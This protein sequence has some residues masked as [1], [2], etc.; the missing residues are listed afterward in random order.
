[1]TSATPTATAGRRTVPNGLWGMLLFVTTEAVL[2]TT[3]VGT[4]FYLHF[5]STAWPPPGIKPPSV[6]LPLALTGLLVLTTAPIVGAAFAARAR[7]R[8]LAMALI[9]LAMGLQ[10]GYL[11]WQLVLFLRDLDTFPA[12]GTAYGSAYFTMLG[13]HHIHVA[14]G[15]L[16][17]LWLLARLTAGLTAYR[18]VSVQ[19]VAIYWVMVNSLAILVVLAQVSPS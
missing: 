6:A 10:G 5:R 7:R 9:L 15:L 11:A 12:D 13:A 16:F 19:A 1:M 18:I 8:G 3:L 14:I 2:L 17:D 4:Y